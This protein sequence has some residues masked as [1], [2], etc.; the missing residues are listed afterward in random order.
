LSTAESS[1][2]PSEP[3]PQS[4]AGR[5]WIKPAI[6]L[7]SLVL[8]IAGLLTFDYFYS[9]TVLGAA[10][11]GG[12]HGFCFSRDPIRV[13]AFRPDCTCIRPWLGASY[14][15]K[16]NSLGFR[17]ETIRQVEAKSSSPRVLILGD[18]GPEGMTDWAQSYV[19]RL[20][21]A[22]PQSEFLN[23]S[24]EGYSPSNYLNTA[25]MVLRDGIDF[26]EAIV[27]IDISDAQDEAAFFHDEGLSGAVGIA[28]G[29]RTKSS[30]Y[31]N[32]RLNINNH[33]LLTNDVF[34]F[35]EKTLVRLGWYHLD[36]GHGGNEFDLER[37]AW[38]YRA[39]SDTEPY[40]TGY[41]PLGLEGGIRK[42][43]QKM[44]TLWRELKERNIPISV[45][46]GPWP[47]QLAHDD[48][49]S[50]EVTIWRDWCASK[51]KRFVDLFPGFFAAKEQCP[52]T[53]PGCWYEK[54]FI[55][56]DTH[57][58][59]TGDAMV[60]DAVG[61]ALSADPVVKRQADAT[62]SANPAP[63]EARR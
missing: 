3:I 19:G 9:S 21:R 59:N 27:F 8:S 42:E 18:S 1:V 4:P 41:A 22:F 5:R 16:T 53:Q 40:E 12:E 26:D 45:V 61:N 36:L 39:I 51:C 23:S 33:L 34:D 25:R 2:I 29:K 24:V 47:A 55:F 11:S 46:V 60:A 43:Q 15:F 28:N 38:T 37:S 30:W 32:L 50:R 48:R 49:N 14:E 17:D 7:A 58:N 56:G 35:L 13:F 44:D 54:D 20:T 63:G 62:T 6:F 10:V 31:S 52:R 57:Y